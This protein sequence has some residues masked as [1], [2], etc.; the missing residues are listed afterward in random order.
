MYGRGGFVFGSSRE[1]N[2]Q[3]AKTAYNFMNFSLAVADA[4][5]LAQNVKNFSELQKQ[6]SLLNEQ[7]GRSGLA[8]RC[9]LVT[10]CGIWR[11][12]G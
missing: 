4:P 10:S 9:R 5:N 3:K 1:W 7:K 8:P 11:F 6:V 2:Y 12:P